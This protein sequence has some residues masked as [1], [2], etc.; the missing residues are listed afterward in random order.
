MLVVRPQMGAMAKY[1]HMVYIGCQPFVRL[2]RR[3]NGNLFRENRNAR[4]ARRGESCH[5]SNVGIYI[6]CT[7]FDWALNLFSIELFC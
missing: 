3:F 4:R 6:T 1:V 7:Y 5:I 2:W